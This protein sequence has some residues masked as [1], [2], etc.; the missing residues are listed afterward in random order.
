M[1]G[2]TAASLTL[3][4]VQSA[5]AATY[6]VVVTNAANSA[7]SNG[8]TL[9]IGAGPA[10]ITSATTASATVNVPFT[11]QMTATNSPIGYVAVNVPAGLT[12]NTSNG[13]ISGTPT[14]A[15][16]VAIDLSA[17]NSAGALGP[18]TVLQLTIAKGTQTI[19]F[20]PSDK[21][22]TDG[23]F[24]LLPAKSSAD[25]DVTYALLGGPANLSGSTVTLT[26]VAGTVSIRASQAGDANYLP[27]SVDRSFAVTVGATAPTITTP[28]QNATAATGAT[29]TFGVVAAGTA[30]LTYQWQRKP[31]GG[32]TFADLANG[33][34]YA[35]VGT[36]TLQVSGLTAPMNGD[37]FRAIVGNPVGTATSSAATLTIGSTDPGN[38]NGLNIHIP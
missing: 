10:V 22:T 38:V 36:A 18:T 25:L 11:Y 33:G 24:A 12:I 27:T 6:T 30:P 19:A 23:P 13:Q 20:A 5:D 7:T 35:G 17:I 15:G 16:S 1:A 34:A 28:P 3:A 21:L 37:Q 29:V 9:A 14:A 31:A 8:A 4:N 32:S 26:G 2:A